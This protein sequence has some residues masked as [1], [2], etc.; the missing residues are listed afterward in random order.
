MA[1][2]E[3]EIKREKAE[4][5]EEKKPER[6]DYD[7]FFKTIL[8]R[9]FWDGL[10]IF[11][12]QLYKDANKNEKV[13][14]L[15]Q[16][17]QKMTFDQKGSPERTDL[18]ANVPL[19]SGAEQLVIAHLEIQGRQGGDLPSRMNRYKEAIHLFHRK[20][21]VGIAIITAQRPK[22]EKTFYSSE[23]YGVRSLYEYI[24]VVVKDL[25]DELL[26]DGDNRIGFVLY[27]AKCAWISGNDEGKKFRYLR[28]ISE[29]WARRGWDAE[30][31]R[32]ILIAIEYLIR[33]NDE[34]YS[35]QFVAHV[36]SLAESMGEEE[37]SMYKSVFERVYTAQGR[38]EGIE[39]GREEGREEGIGQGKIEVARSM[40]ADGLPAETVKKYTGLGEK[41]IFAIR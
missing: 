34:D 40:L 35:R 29:M 21:P 6:I 24:N 38:E 17:L 7:N 2:I 14:F 37:K 33:L 41:E 22:G 12:P 20:E 30:D 25:S 27:A 16:E 9:H 23:V 13:Q 28:E 3:T 39:K 1:E 8:H 32:I 26:L 19:E 5:S 36:A 10:K 31:K 11:H 18:L 15:E 4:A